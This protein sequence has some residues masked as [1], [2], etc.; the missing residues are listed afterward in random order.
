MPKYDSIETIPAKVFFD[1]LKTKDYQQLK[2][3]PKEKGLEEVFMQIYDD[4]FLKSD[5]QTAKEYL[6]LQ[7]EMMANAYKIDVLR[8]SLA[9]YYYEKTTKEMRMAFIEA[10]K[11]G[12]GIIINPDVPFVDEVKRILDIEIGLL[13]NEIAIVK[14]QM[15]SIKS[16]N[17]TEEGDFYDRIVS[18]ANALP[19]NS[20]INDKMVLSVFVALEKSAYKKSEKAK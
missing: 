11:K 18:L 10:V 2:P 16:G 8:S 15:D 14:M 3:K 17:K 12:Y 5:N 20:L 4:Y 9:F 19:N 1:I 7:A 6:R 13:E